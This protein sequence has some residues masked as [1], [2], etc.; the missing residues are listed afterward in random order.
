M[1]LA[2]L[3]ALRP[4]ALF[5]VNGFPFSAWAVIRPWNGEYLTAAPHFNQASKEPVRFYA[6]DAELY[7]PVKTETQ[8]QWRERWTC[9]TPGKPDK[10]GFQWGWAYTA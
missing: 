3:K 1:T 5:N 9:V 2:M 10:D 6:A 8:P 7:E 4:D